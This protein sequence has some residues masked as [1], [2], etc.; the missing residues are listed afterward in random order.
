MYE[1]EGIV[2]YVFNGDTLKVDIDLGFEVWL[3]ST[4]V[5]LKGV[6]APVEKEDLRYLKAKELLINYVLG[7]TVI[8]KSYCSRSGKYKRWLVEIIFMLEGVNVSLNR[9]VLDSGFCKPFNY[10]L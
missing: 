7:R 6:D 2:R 10:T 5:R 8:I 4:I 1:Y 3:R 9:K